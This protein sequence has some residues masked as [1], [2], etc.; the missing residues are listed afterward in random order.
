MSTKR[1]LGFASLLLVLS[2]LSFLPVVFAVEP[3]GA[4]V[5][6]T[7]ISRSPVDVADSEL[8]FAGNVTEMTVL[9]YSVTQSW[10][11]YF[12]NISGTVQLADG[13]DFVMYNWSSATPR[14]EIYASTNSSIQWLNV[15]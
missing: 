9:G 14:G 11:G 4:T 12:G 8:A 10:Q 3:F 15:Q 2:L 1:V 13:S 7:N 5:T 6:V